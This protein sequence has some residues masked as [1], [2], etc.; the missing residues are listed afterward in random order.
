M[1]NHEG[2]APP[3][4][5]SQLAVHGADW[6]LARGQQNIWEDDRSGSVRVKSV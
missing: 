3:F 4:E 6:V 2:G 1:A 5:D